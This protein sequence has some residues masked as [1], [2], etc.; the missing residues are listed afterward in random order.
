MQTQQGETTAGRFSAANQPEAFSKPRSRH[1]GTM[2]ILC[3]HCQSMA[4][5]RSS[6]SLT[7]LYRELRL[8]CSDVDCGGTYVA[9]VTI[10]RMIVP[11]QK[12]NPRVRLKVGQ[13]RPNK[14]A[15]DDAPTD[16]SAAL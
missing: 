13:P 9:S 3:P 4:T 2:K 6:K 5:V 1:G 14:P 7:P 8:Q 11:S 15:N 16:A 10:D 12:P